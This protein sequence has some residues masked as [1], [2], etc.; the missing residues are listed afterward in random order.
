MQVNIQIVVEDQELPNV[1]DI[2]IWAQHALKLH[3]D[4][5]EMT[6]RVVDIEEGRQ[7]NERWRKASGPTNVL[8]FPTDDLAVLPG[9]L[10]DVVICAPLA[11]AEATRDG[12]PIDAHWA[13]LVIHG[14]LHL[15][16]YDHINPEDAE[17]MEQLE[18][19]L[20]ND[21]SYPDPYL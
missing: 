5:V 6:V 8:S 15:L 7:L 4:E 11:N 12:K 9:L 3:C 16:G 13:H 14:T 18:R 21:L 1:E 10:G 2:T 20:L 19:T 17:T